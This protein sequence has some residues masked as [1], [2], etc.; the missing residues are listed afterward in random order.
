MIS[1]DESGSGRPAVF[2]HGL[3]ED[4]RSWEPV[5]PLVRDT[6]R[7]I[8]VDLPGHGSSPDADD[9]SV[10]AMA[11]RVD[12]VIEAAGVTE[13]PL[14]VGHSMG[15]MVVTFLASR[16]AARAVVNVDQPL[17]VGDFAAQVQPMA[18]MLRGDGFDAAIAA[19]FSSLGTERIP[20][21]LGE[22]A[23]AKHAAARKDVVLGSWALVLD[24]PPADL[25][26]MVDA[27]LANLTAPY[28]AI[29]GEELPGYDAWLRER[30]PTASVEV[31]EGDGHYPHLLEP[32]RLAARLLEL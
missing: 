27:S 20:P 8:R 31:W 12:E 3:T 21:P 30:I 25:Q 29:L 4:R 5:I 16:R 9:Y 17:T 15:A 28:L 26:A 18:A 11:D 1:W 32:D 24:T 23:E 10:F 22:W 2:V 7:C 13:P 6:L 19:V 14:L